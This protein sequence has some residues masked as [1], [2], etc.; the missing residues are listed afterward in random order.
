MRERPFSEMEKCP[1]LGYGDGATLSLVQRWEG[2][3]P[4]S[5]LE[6]GES[7]YRAVPKEIM[8]EGDYARLGTLTNTVSA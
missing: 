3:R 4:W 6:E 8:K 2:C 5:L 7:Y 1:S